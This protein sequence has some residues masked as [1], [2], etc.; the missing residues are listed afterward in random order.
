MLRVRNLVA[1]YGPLDVVH[2]ISL[3]VEPGERVALLGSNRAGKTSTLRAISGL[4]RHAA[5]ELS[6]AGNDI[7]TAAA[8]RM[9]ALGIAHVPEGRQVFAGLSV[10]ENLLIGAHVRTDARFRAQREA[11]VYDLFPRL[12]ERREQDAQTLSGGEAQML[13]VGRAL[14]LEPALLMLDEPSQGLAPRVVDEMYAALD[15]MAAQTNVTILLVEQNVVAALDFVS[16]A[17]VLENGAITLEG[18]SDTLAR[19]DRV[20]AAFLGV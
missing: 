13:A 19:D 1:G 15:R 10:R 14:M 16:R 11:V 9:A 18:S 8:H 4:I 12:H 3:H 2:G 5:D 17:Y 6:V 7:R 20:R